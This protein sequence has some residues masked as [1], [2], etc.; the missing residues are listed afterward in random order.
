MPRLLVLVN[1]SVDRLYGD[2]RSTLL[3]AETDVVL[4]TEAG[5][6]ATVEAPV[7]IGGATFVPIESRT[8]PNESMLATLGELSFAAGLFEAVDDGALRGVPGGLRRGRWPTSL[9]TIQRYRGKTNETFTRLLVNVARGLFVRA[10]SEARRRVL[11]PLAGRGTT[12]NAVMYA[13]MDAAG[14]ELNGAGVDQYVA[15]ISR[16]LKDHRVKHRLDRSSVRG[17]RG[18]RCTRVDVYYGTS[19]AEVASRRSGALTIV[20]GDTSN[21]A[22][23]FGTKAFDALVTDLPYG[24][25]HGSTAGDRLSRSAVGLVSDAAAAWRAALRP[26]APA[27]LAFNQLTTDRD[28]LLAAL[29]EAGFEVVDLAASLEHQVDASIRRD[30]VVVRRPGPAR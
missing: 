27:V 12:L 29:V 28:E 10:G 24:V 20:N 4:R 5:W 3:H 18:E 7:D 22:T 9:L 17:A 16:W 23:W 6:E 21:V 13:D 11:D 25:Q 1:P 14:I 26:G 8:A 30:V 19:K 2:L 15:F